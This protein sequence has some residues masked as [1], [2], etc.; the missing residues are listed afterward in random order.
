MQNFPYKFRVSTCWELP[1]ST[2]NQPP[3]PANTVSPKPKLSIL[4]LV[5]QLLCHSTMTYHTTDEDLGLVKMTDPSCIPNDI[6]YLFKTTVFP[7][8]QYMC[9]HQHILYTNWWERF[10]LGSTWSC[11]YHS[12]L[13]LL[14][15]EWYHG[16]QSK[17]IP[18]F[19]LL[20]FP[21]N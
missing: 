1:T 3:W 2:T 16:S 19:P 14:H 10:N 4:M 20:S 17:E 7:V 9:I 15:S 11:L 6:L 12:L 13:L 8:G 21:V 18:G 5:G